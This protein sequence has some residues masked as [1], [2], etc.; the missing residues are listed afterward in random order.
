MGIKT[1]SFLK[2]SNR[3]FNNILDTVGGPQNVKSV[4][5]ATNLTTD[6]CGTIILG[7]VGTEQAA[8]TGFTVNL[9]AP[10]KGA[11][12]KF[13]LAAPSIANDDTAEIF[14]KTTSDGTTAA[15]LGVGMVYVNGAPANVVAVADTVEFVKAKAT[16]GDYAECISDGTNWFFTIF[17]DANGAVTFS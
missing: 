16:A 4:N 3:D 9:P 7:V 13:I 17:G 1:R 11:Y 12:F 5:A 6:D 2:T 10:V 15:D 8:S 14:I